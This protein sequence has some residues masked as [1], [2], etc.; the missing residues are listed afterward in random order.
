M[1]MASGKTGQ[2]VESQKGRAVE[3][4]VGAILLLQSDGVLRVSVPLVDDEGV[5]LVVGRRQND[6]VLLLQIK[7]RFTL[8]RLGSYRAD[9]RRATCSPQHTSKCL[10][11]VYYDKQKAALGD[12][13]WLI[14]VPKFCRLLRNQR[15][16]R[17]VYV[18]QSR[19]R[20]KGDM[21]A[22]FRVSTTHI[23]QEVVKRLR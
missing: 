6:K 3:Q 1:Q 5:D 10:L 20:A 22:P 19:F 18:F 11:F 23:A 17:P 14:P 15:L 21:W 2:S 12:Y 13:C 16:T 7:S 4:L 8:T 9:V